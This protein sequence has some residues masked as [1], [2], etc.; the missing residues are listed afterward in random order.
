MGEYDKI[1]M[2]CLLERIVLSFE[3]LLLDIVPRVDEFDMLPILALQRVV[4]KAY[5]TLPSIGIELLTRVK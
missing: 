5:R 3:D 2:I 1:L 4:A